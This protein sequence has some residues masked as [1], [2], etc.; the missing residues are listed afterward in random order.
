MASRIFALLALLSL[1]SLAACL[2]DQLTWYDDRCLRLGFERGSTSFNS[3][4]ER[5]RQWIAEN[6]RRARDHIGP[7]S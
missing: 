5:D 3:C 2:G 7:Y 4:I 6:Q 1:S